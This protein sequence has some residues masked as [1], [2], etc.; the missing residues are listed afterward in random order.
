MKDLPMDPPSAPERRRRRS[1]RNSV[2]QQEGEKRWRPNARVMGGVLAALVLIVGV[3]LLLHRGGAPHGQVLATVDG[4]EV[5]VQDLEAEAR[6]SGVPDLPST[7]AVLLDR[8][9]NRRLLA[10]SAHQQHLDQIPTAPSDLARVEQTWL[11]QQALRQVLTAPGPPDPEA[12]A[13]F[14]ASRPFSFAK[15]TSSTLDTLTVLGGERLASSLQSFTDLDLAATFVRR[16]GLKA[17]RATSAVDSAQLPPQI[18]ARLAAAPAGSMMLRVEPG[19]LMMSRVG[20]RSPV[21]LPEAAERAYAQQ[22]WAEQAA[23]D[24]VRAEVAR[25]RRSSHVVYARPNATAKA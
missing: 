23:A 2:F 11:A 8:V 1:R 6:A 22:L 9:I 12:L 5:T 7:R 21:S 24:R 19:R 16:L 18:A 25:L 15:R 20:T 13:R 17:V 10:Q 14:E 4:A 3:S